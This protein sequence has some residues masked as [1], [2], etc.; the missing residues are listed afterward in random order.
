MQEQIQLLKNSGEVV[1]GYCRKPNS[2][3]THDAR[4]CS[5]QLMVDQ[6]INRCHVQKVFVSP[7][8]DPYLP[9]MD[10]DKKLRKRDLQDLNSVDG[11]TRG[12]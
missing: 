11:T 10:R 8:S 12:K 2:N 6:L 7:K 1:V 4:F 9:L 3:E 5:I